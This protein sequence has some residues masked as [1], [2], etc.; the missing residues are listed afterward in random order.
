[1]NALLSLL[2]TNLFHSPS[3]PLTSGRRTQ[4][5]TLRENRL[6]ASTYRLDW[7]HG[8]SPMSFDLTVEDRERQRVD[9]MADV[10]RLV[11]SAGYRVKPV[12]LGLIITAKG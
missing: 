10:T 3:R 12:G 6:S 11:A 9:V 2:T 5:W 7:F 8:P 4:G 1:M